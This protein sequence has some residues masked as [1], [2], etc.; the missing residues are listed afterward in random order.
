MS[1]SE[2]AVAP[3]VKAPILRKLRRVMPSQKREDGPGMFSMTGPF[4]GKEVGWR[5]LVPGRVPR[6]P[7]LVYVQNGSGAEADVGI[8]DKSTAKTRECQGSFTPARNGKPCG[9]D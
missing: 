8:I 1:A 3:K 9:G 4:G 5:S 6:T 7:R 2:N